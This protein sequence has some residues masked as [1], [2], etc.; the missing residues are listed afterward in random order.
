MTKRKWFT[1]IQ[2]SCPDDGCCYIEHGADDRWYVYM[3]DEHG[4]LLEGFPLLTEETFDSIKFAIKWVDDN[5]PIRKL[6]D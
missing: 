1:G 2:T 3:S 5:V 6:I 4:G